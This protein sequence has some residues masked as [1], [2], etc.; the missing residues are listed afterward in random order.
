MLPSVAKSTASLGP[1][2][3]YEFL[4]HISEDNMIMGSDYGHQDQSKE[5][6]MVGVMRR[7]K[8]ISPAVIE[9]ILCDNPRR[10]YGL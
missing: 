6:G 5:D 9:K 4:T 8:S 7:K 2:R 3:G 1:T 10:F